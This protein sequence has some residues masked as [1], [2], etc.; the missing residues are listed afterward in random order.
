MSHDSAGAWADGR[1]LYLSLW[2][3]DLWP[4]S[5]RGRHS[6]WIGQAQIQRREHFQWVSMVAIH[7]GLQHA[8]GQVY[9]KKEEFSTIYLTTE[10]TN[11][12]KSLYLI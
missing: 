11:I 2:S 4:G 8:S 10:L 9:L 12:A 5:H 3:L 6:D 1:D 7:H